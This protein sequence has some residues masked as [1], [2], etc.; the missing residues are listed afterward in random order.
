MKLGLR[1]AVSFVVVCTGIASARAQD[2]IRLKDGQVVKCA[3]LRMDSMAVFATDWEFRGLAMPPLKVYTRHE[4]QSVWF[5]EPRELTATKLPYVPHP[6]G[7]EAGGSIALQT[8]LEPGIK[9]RLLILAAAQ[10]AFTVVKQL[11]LEVDA[12]FAFPSVDKRDPW[13]SSHNGYQLSFNVVGHPVRWHGFVPFLLLGAGASTGIPLGDV[14]VPPA[15]APNGNQPNREL[16]NAGLGIKWGAGG[17]GYRIEWRH[18]YYQWSSGPVNE[19]ADAS[20][21]RASLFIYR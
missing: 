2:Y 19:S 13:R 10:G 15:S 21:I 7:W 3:I 20:L 6:R 12:D 11:S 4:M 16:L 8:W 17:L 14:L 5:E 18:S 9:R 1:F